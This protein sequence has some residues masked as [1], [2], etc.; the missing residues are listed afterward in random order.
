MIVGTSADSPITVEQVGK[1][2]SATQSPLIV[3]AE[4][5]DQTR[6]TLEVYKAGADEVLPKPFVP[7]ALIGA[8][9]AEMRRPGPA[10]LVPLATRI[11][12]GALVFDA[13]HREVAGKEG[14]VQL[15]KREWQLLAFFLANP[16]QFFTA[17]EVKLQAW[18][19]DSSDEQFRGYVARVRR[20]LSRFSKHCRVVTAKAKGYCLAV[21]L[22]A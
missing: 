7:D 8:I 1:L 20:K 4:A 10:S 14:S 18:G 17:G 9:K 15:T 22:G 13:E 3:L 11:E 2:R 19:P 6:E 16:N 5:Y 12:L 21:D